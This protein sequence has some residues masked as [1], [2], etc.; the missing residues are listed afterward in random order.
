MSDYAP[1]ISQPSI[2]EIGSGYFEPRRVALD[3]RRDH[4]YPVQLALHYRIYI[5]RSN[6]LTGDTFTHDISSGGVSFQGSKVLPAGAD[7]ELA[8]TWPFR[9]EGVCRLKLVVFGRV[10]RSDQITTAIKMQRYEFRT[11]GMDHLE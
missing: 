7:I 8:I 6:I 1:H 9:L 5:D 4:R 3:R 2:L 10:V 11:A